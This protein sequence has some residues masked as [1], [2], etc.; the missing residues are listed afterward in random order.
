MLCSKQ[1]NSFRILSTL[2]DFCK[3]MY[4][5]PMETWQELIIA[6]FTAYSLAALIKGVKESYKGK[7]TNGL[8]GIYALTGAFVWADAVIFGL[9]WVFASFVSIY[10]KD[11]ILF[12]LFQSVF[13]TIRGWGEAVYFF[14]QQFS[15]QVKVKPKDMW[16]YGFFKNES[17]WFVRQIQWQCVMV[18]GIISTIYLAKIWF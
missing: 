15:K 14:N 5:T 1:Q 13:W 3:R 9:F 16:G 6:A 18:I 17:I 4:N 12:L 10:L 2:R 8:T 7:N 11:W